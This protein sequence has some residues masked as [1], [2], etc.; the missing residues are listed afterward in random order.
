MNIYYM[1]ENITKSR[2]PIKVW[3]EQVQRNVGAT[4]CPAQEYEPHTER[5]GEPESDGVGP[6]AGLR[7]VNNTDDT[8][9]DTF[10]K[11]NK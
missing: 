1:G 4:Q 2:F 8:R 10:P 6:D 7:S 3:N 11:E 9:V 5:W